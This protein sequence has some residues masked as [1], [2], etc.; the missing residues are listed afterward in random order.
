[1]Y[2]N[3]TPN[4]YISPTYSIH[5]VIAPTFTSVLYNILNNDFYCI[6][7]ASGVDEIISRCRLRN[8]VGCWRVCHSLLKDYVYIFHLQI[9]PLTPMR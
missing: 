4:Y 6:N 8:F 3:R 1:M 2:I 9:L 5:E 7:F